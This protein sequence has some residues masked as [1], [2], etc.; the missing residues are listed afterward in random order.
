PRSNPRMGNMT[1]IGARQQGGPAGLK[2][3]NVR[4]GTAGRIHNTLFLDWTDGFDIDDVETLNQGCTDGN[5]LNP[6]GLALKN[7]KLFNSRNGSNDNST[8]SAT[9]GPSPKRA[10]A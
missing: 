10:N 4:R 7:V 9:G 5:T 2:G 8:G 3:A 1:M 6:A